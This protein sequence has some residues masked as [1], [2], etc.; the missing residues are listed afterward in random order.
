MAWEGSLEVCVYE[1]GWD[2]L[3]PGSPVIISNITDNS[4]RTPITGGQQTEGGVPVPPGVTSAVEKVH[5]VGGAL[6]EYGYMYM[7]D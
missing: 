3:L 1:C 2:A 4:H 5:P 6:G 7:Y